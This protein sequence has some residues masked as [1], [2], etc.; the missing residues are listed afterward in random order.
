MAE[1]AAA[2]H[3]SNSKMSMPGFYKRVR[4]P[5]ERERRYMTSVVPISEKLLRDAKAR[6]GWGEPA[7]TVC[8]QITTQPALTVNGIFD[9]YQ[10]EV[11]NAWM[12][13]PTSGAR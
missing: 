8:E 11:V 10:R 12:M 1:L 3:D 7:C 13:K 6:N 9:D 5:N 4:L 2:L